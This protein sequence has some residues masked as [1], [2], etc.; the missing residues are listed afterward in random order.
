MPC[1]TI[2]MHSGE[3]MYFRYVCCR[4]EFGFLNCDDIC[5]CVVKKQFELL[6]FVSIPFILICSMVRYL[7]LLLLG[8][9]PCVVSVVMCWSLVCL[10]GCRGTLCGCG[11]CCDCDACTVV[12]V[13]L[14]MLVWGMEE[15]W[16]W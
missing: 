9:C 6:E 14:C 12:C 8:L 15:M 10:L 4:G 3:V 16:L 13:A 7:S 11:V 1:A 2:G 5:M